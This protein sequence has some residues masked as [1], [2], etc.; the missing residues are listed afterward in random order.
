[1]SSFGPLDMASVVMPLPTGNQLYPIRSPPRQLL[2]LV[3]MLLALWLMVLTKIPVFQLEGKAGCNL[4]QAWTECRL[5]MLVVHQE[6]GVMQFEDSMIE[7]PVC[8]DRI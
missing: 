1:M 8:V 5:I 3:Q 6:L 2:I 7:Q 4:G